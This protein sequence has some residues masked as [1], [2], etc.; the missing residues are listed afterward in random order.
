M[1]P[2]S[3]IG[4]NCKNIGVIRITPGC[5]EVDPYICGVLFSATIIQLTRM[6]FIVS[7]DLLAP[8]V[9]DW[10]FIVII[11]R[12]HVTS[13]TLLHSIYHCFMSIPFALIHHEVIIVF[14]SQT[15]IPFSTFL[16]VVSHIRVNLCAPLTS[17]TQH[18]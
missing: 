13:H 15:S 8:A 14:V 2:D 11:H 4:L 17:A 18:F 10:V 7:I 16:F 9:Y 3:H 1:W 12:P 6:K 5:P